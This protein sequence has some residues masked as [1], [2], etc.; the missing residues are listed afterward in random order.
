MIVLQCS[1]SSLPF[2]SDHRA[3]ATVIRAGGALGERRVELYPELGPDLRL[4]LSCLFVY[5]R[6]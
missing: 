4:F 3:E 6:V 5:S 2:F 1:F